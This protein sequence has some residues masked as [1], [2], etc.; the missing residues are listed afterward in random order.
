M[1]IIWKAPSTIL[2]QLNEL[3]Q[4]HHSPRLDAA[5]FVVAFNESKPFV[6]NRF[7]WGSLKRFSDFHKIWQG[8]K[9]E[10]WQSML[11]PD[12]QLALLDLHLCRCAPEYVPE[13]VIEGKKKKVI[14]DEWG[15]VK[16]TNELKYDDNGNPK[17]V[18]TPLDIEVFMENVSRYGLWCSKFCDLTTITDAGG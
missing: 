6:K 18:V 4:K 7:N 15:R 5:E 8:Q 11:T 2:D 16:Y 1:S 10:I 3:K 12:Q 17:W 13:S 14:K 9:Y